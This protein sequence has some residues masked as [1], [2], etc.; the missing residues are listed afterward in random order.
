MK[1]PGMELLGKC[2]EF[3]LQLILDR[4]ARRHFDGVADTIAEQIYQGYW[5]DA[6][7]QAPI[8]FY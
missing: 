3:L 5:F 2:Y 4:R 6:A 8:G 7:T 1:S